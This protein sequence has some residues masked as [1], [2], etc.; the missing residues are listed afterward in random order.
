MMGVSGTKG[1][2]AVV[3]GRGARTVVPTA[4]V[5]LTTTQASVDSMLVV[6]VK[7]SEMVL[8]LVSGESVRDDRRL[9]KERSLRGAGV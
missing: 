3:D 9:S 6:G 7:T 2:S 5:L 4:V 1:R 8:V